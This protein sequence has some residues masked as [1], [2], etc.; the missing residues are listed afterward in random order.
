MNLLPRKLIGEISN[1]LPTKDILA[2]VGPKQAGKTTLLKMLREE[3]RDRWPTTKDVIIFDLEEPVH[4]NALN[5]GTRNLREWCLFSGADPNK[6][7]VIMIDEIQNLKDPSG[8]LDGLARFEPNLPNLKVIIAGST[9]FTARPFSNFN[10][11]HLK[12]FNLLPLDFEEFLIFKGY[13]ELCNLK[14]RAC[15]LS[16]PNRRPQIDTKRLSPVQSQLQTLF[17]EF[18][19]YGGFPGVV[20]ARS[21]K[22]KLRKLKNLMDTFEFKGVNLLFNVARFDAF[23]VFFR[24]MAGSAGELLNINAISKTLRIGRDTVKRYLTVLENS[25]MAHTLPP[26]HN[27]HAKELTKKKKF[28]FSDTGIRNLAIGNFTELRFRPDREQLFENAVYCQLMKNLDAEDN[29][30]FWRTISRNEVAFVI[31]GKHRVTY[32]VN[33]GP[34][35]HSNRTGGSRKFSKLYPSFQNMVISLDAFEQQNWNLKLEGWMV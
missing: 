8:F 20:L 22:D 19:L 12:I 2:V 28:Y 10:P 25:Y 4:L 21:K 9:S 29:L 26:F 17:E 1:C 34:G 15:H 30:Y 18:V 3:I 5:R 35:G 13:H 23:R 32:D 16:M 27:G 24:M 14:T 33:V 11:E 7:L 6:D 31:S